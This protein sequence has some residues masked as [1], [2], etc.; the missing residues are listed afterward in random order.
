MI[1]LPSAATAASV[2]GFWTVLLLLGAA[3]A[4][5]LY[6]LVLPHPVFL[7]GCVAALLG[8]AA[9]AWRRPVKLQTA[10][11]VCSGTIRKRIVPGVRRW[12]LAVVFFLVILPN[13]S[14]GRRMPGASFVQS[15]RG[16]KAKEI[17][18]LIG[19]SGDADIVPG[20]EGNA[21]WLTMLCRWMRETRNGWAFA[22]L[23]FMLLLS[24]LNV[25]EKSAQSEETYTLF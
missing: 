8:L 18:N 21:S 25:D 15:D 24:V 13:R 23:P 7:A 5:G 1:Y 17:S 19:G 4:G 22:L 10:Y 12:I 11:T 9:I 2:K 16:W 3:L 6:R 14:L 20:D